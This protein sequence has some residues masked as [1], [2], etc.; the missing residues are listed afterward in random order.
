MLFKKIFLVLIFFRVEVS[1]LEIFVSQIF[2]CSKVACDGSSNAPFN[3]IIDA[4]RHIE[5]LMTNQNNDFSVTIFLDEN[6]VSV[7][8]IAEYDLRN[9]EREVFFSSSNS[10]LYRFLY[11]VVW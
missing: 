7:Y 9:K 5:V 4:F 3:R 10:N 1:N 8:T 11:K 6:G 2:D